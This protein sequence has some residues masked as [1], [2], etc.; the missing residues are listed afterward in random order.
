MFLPLAVT[1]AAGVEEGGGS[2]AGSL[3][4]IRHGETTWN[5]ENRFQGQQDVPLSDDGRRQ[6]ALL[7]LRFRCQFREL[8]FDALWSSDLTRARE[9]AAPV[10]EALGL[11]LREHSGLREINFGRWEGLTFAQIEKVF[12]ENV[13]CYREDPVRT[14]PPEGESFLAV[15]ARAV[16]ALEEILAGE[17]RRL[18][19][20]AHGG[21][22]KAILCHL[23]GWD[24]AARNRLALDNAS[25][26]VVNYRGGK[27]RLNKLNDT[28]HLEPWAVAGLSIPGSVLKEDA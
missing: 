15:Q 19:L 3:F 14:S 27:A 24:L 17:G 20:V 26:T 4:L 21:T 6:A 7:A 8:R 25:L 22:L 2:V 1:P 10:A 12:P 11:P 16:S 23:L 5:H 28:A 9:T 18:I 13:A